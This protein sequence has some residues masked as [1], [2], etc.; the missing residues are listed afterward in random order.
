MRLPLLILHIS[1]GTL[2]ILSG[3]A[4]MFL[5]KGSRR[6]AIAGQAFVASMLTM[7][8]CG[9]VLALMKHEMNN[10]F[11][12]IL[13]L[14]LVATAWATALRGG[15]VG[16]LEPGSAVPPSCSTRMSR[17]AP[18]GCAAAS[19]WATSAARASRSAAR[20]LAIV[21]IPYTAAAITSE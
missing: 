15:G 18:I 10:V 6:H 20:G 21:A 2:G 17:M 7:A 19:L 8:S 4:A 16:W 13:T 11:G 9:A 1:G 5:R 14:Y 12:G 3:F